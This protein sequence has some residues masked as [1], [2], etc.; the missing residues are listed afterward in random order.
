V[1][2][3]RKQAITDEFYD[4]YVQRVFGIG[5]GEDEPRFRSLIGEGIA[6][7]PE[8]TGDDIRLFAVELMNRMNFCQNLE[9]DDH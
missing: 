6:A 1:I 9:G 4:E 8:A 5:D 7:P 3:K 2:K